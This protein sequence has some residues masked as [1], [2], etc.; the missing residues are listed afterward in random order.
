MIE[1]HVKAKKGEGGMSI[2][3]DILKQLPKNDNDIFFVID[4]G[5]Y[6]W[7]DRNK[8]PTAEFQMIK[9]G[10]DLNLSSISNINILEMGLTKFSNGMD[11]YYNDDIIIKLKSFIEDNIPSNIRNRVFLLYKTITEE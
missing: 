1:I 11:A 8:I 4:D 7:A 9:N 3:E 6:F 5:H 10:Y 2:L